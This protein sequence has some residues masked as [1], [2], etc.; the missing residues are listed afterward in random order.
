[1][2]T[3]LEKGY[4]LT[5]DFGN[6]TSRPCFVKYINRFVY[7]TITGRMTQKMY[8]KFKLKWIGSKIILCQ[9]ILQ[10]KE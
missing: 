2:R 9:I 6:V 10:K 4:C 3:G 7:A 1:M 8:K 5:E